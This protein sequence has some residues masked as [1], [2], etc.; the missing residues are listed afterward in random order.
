MEVRIPRRSGAA[1]PK[2]RAE[3]WAWLDSIVGKL[4]ADFAEAVGEQPKQQ[5]RPAL[6][7][8]FR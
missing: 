1:I 5:D 8:L 6:K 7:T 4:G 2:P 3:D